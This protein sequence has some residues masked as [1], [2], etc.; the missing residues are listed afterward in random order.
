MWPFAFCALVIV[1]VPLKAED[2][3]MALAKN[4]SAVFTALMLATSRQ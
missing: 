3:A 2:N 1:C 4:R